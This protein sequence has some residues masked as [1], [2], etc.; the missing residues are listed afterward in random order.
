MRSTDR[1]KPFATELRISSASRPMRAAEQ[2]E[3][4]KPFRRRAEVG[5]RGAA[6]PGAVE[7]RR[8]AQHMEF[9]L[10]GRLVGRVAVRRR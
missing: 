8:P 7:W 10:A 5:E 9:G 1:T 6:D 3:G 4:A 2:G